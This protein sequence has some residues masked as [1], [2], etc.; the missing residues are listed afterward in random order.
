MQTLES[1]ERKARRADGLAAPAAGRENPRR[2]AP[3]TGWDRVA[4]RLVLAAILLASLAL[5]GVWAVKLPFLQEHDENA[6]ADYAFTLYTTHRPVPAA[7]RRIASDVHP[8]VRYIERISG[9]HQMRR[10][11]DGRVPSGYGSVAFYKAANAKAPHVAKDFLESNGGRIPYVSRTYSFFYYALDAI[12]IGAGAVIGHGSPIAEFLGAR[13]FGVVLLAASLLLCFATM[14]ELRIRR[15]IALALLATI[16]FLPLTSWMSG[17]VQPDNL[18]FT[19]VALVFYLAVRL[20]REPNG[21]RAAGFMGLALALLALTK[22]QYFVAVAVPAVADRALRFLARGRSPLDWGAFL[23]LIA[24]P[25]LVTGSMAQALVDGAGGQVASFVAINGNPLAAASHAG[26]LSLVS[27][28]VRAFVKTWTEFF[29]HGFTFFGFWGEFSWARTQVSFGSA[30]MTQVVYSIIG[31]ASLAVSVLMVARFA[32]RVVPGVVRVLRR[33]GFLAAARLMTSN[34]ILNAYVC[35]LAIMLAINISTDSA[36]AD[37]GRYWL[38]FVLPAL[39]CATFYAPQVFSRRPRKVLGL[40]L[41][42]GA[43]AYS[44]VAAVAALSTLQLHYYEPSRHEV[45]DETLAIVRRFGPYRL[46]G[47]FDHGMKTVRCCAIIPVEGA[48]IDSRNDGTPRF[49]DIV[50][51]GRPQSRA[52]VGIRD[53]ELAYDMLDDALVDTGFAGE[54]DLGRLSPGRHELRLAIGEHSRN[55]PY[56]STERIN[57]FVLPRS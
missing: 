19:A 29:Y 25:S 54:L 1:F 11:L 41:G 56:L 4:S 30:A 5:A 57:F 50:V 23:V 44:M 32:V 28:I 26:P 3:V 14:R 13:L 55:R 42:G 6:H 38:P 27:L 22:S 45:S 39:L 40:A 37:E 47:V 31:G 49:V 9:F 18:S 8:T 53:A 46:R 16:G 36:M 15:P 52:R 48:A 2:T 34:V 51:D 43:L 24:L 35:F 12:A 33:R 7:G 10:N 21:Y 20:R 17:S